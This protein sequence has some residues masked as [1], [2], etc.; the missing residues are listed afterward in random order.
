M[1]VPP[2]KSL[3]LPRNEQ[4]E[5]KAYDMLKRAISMKTEEGNENFKADANFMLGMYY[6]EKGI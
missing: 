5:A 3:F 4:N 2:G 6:L 1:N